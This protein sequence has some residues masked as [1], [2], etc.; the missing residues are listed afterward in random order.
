[1]IA[2]VVG[3]DQLVTIK[4][5]GM[6]HIWDQYTKEAKT[7]K[8]DTSQVKNKINFHSNNLFNLNFKIFIIII[9]FSPLSWSH[10]PRILILSLLVI[11]LFGEL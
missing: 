6:I 9:I 5:K 4:Q 8:T 11:A 3:K 1:L 2:T 7:V 10:I